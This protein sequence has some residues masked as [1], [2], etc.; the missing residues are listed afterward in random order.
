[1]EKIS[2]IRFG[3]IRMSRN[4]KVK[5]GKGQSMA[6][7]FMGIVFCVIGLFVVIPTFGPF[8]IFWTIAAVVITFMNG[9]NAFTDKGIATHEITI[10][11][12]DNQY[13]QENP[14]YSKTSEERLNELQSLYNKS[15]IT[16]DEYQEKRKKILNEI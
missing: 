7:F 11:E 4:I 14:D 2:V 3:G 9:Y 5:P 1:M 6:G 10:D 8:G 15:M 12:D 16:Y 13:K